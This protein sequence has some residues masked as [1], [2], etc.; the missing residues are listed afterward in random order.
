MQ[1]MIGRDRPAAARTTATA[2]ETAM[3]RSELRRQEL[4]LE[5]DR[6]QLLKRVNK[7]AKEK[8]GIFESGAG[9]Q[10]P[11]QE[12]LPAKLRIE[13]DYLEHRSMWRDLGII[14]QTVVALVR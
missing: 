7:L 9:E 5:K 4:L 11:E 10:V 13:L 12:V 2:S 14:A 1:V 3:T 6:T 8:Q